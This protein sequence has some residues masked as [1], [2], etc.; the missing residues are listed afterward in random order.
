MES[1][2]A[3][4][5][6]RAKSETNFLPNFPDGENGDTLESVRKQLENEARK[7]LPDSADVNKMDQTFSLQRKEI[8]EERPPVKRMMERW[9]VLFTE[10]QVWPTYKAP[11]GTTPQ[12]I[13]FIV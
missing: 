8:V 10:S 2:H 6:K 4:T 1:H 13:I 7:R 11:H 9:P 12:L 5:L 3:V